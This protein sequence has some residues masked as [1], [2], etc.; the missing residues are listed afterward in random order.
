MRPALLLFATLLALVGHAADDSA[1]APVAK[2]P[3]RQAKGQSPLP[4]SVAGV[5]DEEY[6]RIRAAL[7]ATYGDEKLVVAR[8]RIA[9]L[10]ERTRFASGRQEA[11]DLKNDFDQARDVIVKATLEAVQK[12]DPTV[13]K[14]SLVLTLNAVEDLTK[15][16]GQEA[17]QKQ[18]EKQIAE[19]KLARKD[20]PETKPDLPVAKA[21]EDKPNTPVAILA[22][23]E[24]VS[25]ED[26]RKF[27]AAALAARSDPTVKELKAKQAE[28]RKQSE[29][30]SVD[31]RKGMRG[32]FEAIMADVH[33]ATLAAI[34]K[35]A[36][37]LSRESADKI[38]ETVES[39]IIAANQKIA[40]KASTKTPLKP[41]P[42][43]DKK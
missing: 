26:M 39:R 22:D 30:A 24:G 5:P 20:T 32:E 15:K 34:L 12:Q 33:K 29:Y 41:F 10:K 3:A 21:T 27:R 11:E 14:D 8:K 35:S 9:E 6:A 23:V 31:E 1:R 37:T 42:F 17:L 28:L 18:R 36:P 25:A 2:I 16:R 19:A 13:S 43:A 38:L 4:D 7:M 40:Q